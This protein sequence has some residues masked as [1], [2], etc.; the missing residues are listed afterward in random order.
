MNWE[1]VGVMVAVS[2][3]VSSFMAY[4]VSLM[5]R[6]AIAE[7]SNKITGELHQLVRSNYVDRAVYESSMEHF[8]E[9]LN[10]LEEGA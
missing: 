3:T 7:A 10:R 8:R 1:A 6:S 2:A 9:R 5:I 4:V